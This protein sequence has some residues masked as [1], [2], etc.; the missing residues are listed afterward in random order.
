M[1]VM[2]VM[3]KNVDFIAPDV[4]L[5][6]VAR[7]IFGNKING[8][9]VC[10]DRKVIGFITEKDILA[11]FLPSMHD[12]MED[13]LHEGDFEHMEKKLDDILSL[14]ASK[15]MSRDPK[16]ISSDTPLL[17]AQ[18]IMMV[19]KIGRLPVVDEKG[20]LVGILSKGDIF[21]SLVGEKLPLEKD[22]HFHDW[23]SRRYDLIIDQKTRLAKEIPDL[24]K[25]FRKEKVKNILDVGCGTGVH[26]IALAQ[27]G[28]NVVGIDTS[29]RMIYVADEKT[30]SLPEI[31]K[32]KLKFIKTEYKDLDKVLSR[33]F[34]AAIFMGSGL[35]HTNSQQVL[36]EVNKILGTKGIIVCQVSNYD[37]VIKSQKRLYDFNIRK[38]PFPE[39]REQ[40]FLRF[41]DPAEEGFFIQNVCVF[42][43]GSKKWV[44]RGLRT[45]PVY[46]LNQ[47]KLKSSL[48][49]IGFTNIKYFG[50]EKGFFY[51]YL[52]RKPFNPSK[53]DVLVVVAKR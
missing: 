16:T 25:L 31:V 41:Y 33:T 26:S 50:G 51:D 8:V 1:K 47:A 13:P 53:S 32:G 36:R 22:E 45:M 21:R 23:L 38:S 2:D 20:N 11:Q 40:A 49:K 17:K 6:G 27:E 5:L 10:K 29:S 37:K 44:F 43:R 46:P 35:P 18:S 34:D 48:A 14:P 3:Q 4:P 39:E 9:P 19:N 42:A 7:L 12:Y 28:F 30:D 15:I 24:V 52:F